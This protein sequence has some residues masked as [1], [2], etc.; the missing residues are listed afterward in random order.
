MG[1]AAQP[2]EIVEEQALGEKAEGLL[3]NNFIKQ[4]KTGVLL[5]ERK[6]LSLRLSTRTAH[7]DASDFSPRNLPQIA[8]PATGAEEIGNP[9]ILQSAAN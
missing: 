2:H 4:N 8:S 1:V 6:L 5:T 3:L 9:S 7:S